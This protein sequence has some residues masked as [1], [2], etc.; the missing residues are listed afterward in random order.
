MHAAATPDGVDFVDED[1]ARRRLTS[2]FE[3]VEGA[4]HQCLAGPWLAD[5]QHAFRNARSER[6]KLFGVLEELDDF[7]QLDLRLRSAG[8]I[9]KGNEGLVHASRFGPAPAK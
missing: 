1:D 6:V 9:V 5:E 7:R 8:H 3:E 4:R 2:L